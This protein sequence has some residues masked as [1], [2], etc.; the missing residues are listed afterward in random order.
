MKIKR[1]YD[2]EK[3]ENSILGIKPVFP[4]NP[5][6]IDMVIMFLSGLLLYGIALWIL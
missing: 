6:L 2:P 3:K 4:F 5:L 1:Y